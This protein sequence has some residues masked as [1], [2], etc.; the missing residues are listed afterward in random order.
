[1]RVPSLVAVLALALASSAAAQYRTAPERATP[2]FGFIG[3]YTGVSDSCS[4]WSVQV[5]DLERPWNTRIEVTFTPESETT[6]LRFSRDI[7]DL[8]EREW[9][10][11]GPGGYVD[12]VARLSA[13]PAHEMEVCVG[14]EQ[15]EFPSSVPISFEARGTWIGSRDEATAVPTASDWTG[16]DVELYNRL[17]FDAHDRPDGFRDRQSWMLPYAAPYYYIR[18][19]GTNGCGPNWRM[20]LDTLHYWR[21][22]IQVIVEQVTG[23]PYRK[24]VEA[25]CEPRGREYGWVIVK[26]VTAG[27]Y[28]QEEGEDWGNAGARALAGATHGVIWFGYDGNQR[29]LDQWHKEAIAHELGHSLGL[30]H[31]GRPETIMHAGRRTRSAS[32][33]HILTPQEE[34]AARRAF[35]VGHGARYCDELMNNCS[36]ATYGPAIA[37]RPGVQIGAIRDPLVIVEPPAPPPQW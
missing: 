4:V 20:N 16:L 19:G 8:G 33:F 14:R 27:E 6:F 3:E 1:M 5:P 2:W 17:V 23:V 30:H 15:T 35:E 29:P 13:G 9:W 22:V 26:Y 25:G 32:A 21:A 18:L 37:D 28:L 10:A 7:S 24:R 11:S 12:V 34:T 36:S 31:S